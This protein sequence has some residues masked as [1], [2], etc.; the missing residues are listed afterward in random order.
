VPKAKG[1]LGRGLSALIPQSPT[2]QPEEAVAPSASE[3]DPPVGSP[4][5][6]TSSA[7]GGLVNLPI[8]SIEP[9]PRQPR[10]NFAVDRL[11]ELAESIRT[12]GVIQPLVVTFGAENGR[13]HLVAGER[14]WRASMLAGLE[15]VP[16]VV[17]DA[18]PREMLEL[19]LVENIQRADLNPLEEAAAYRALVD[20][21]GLKQEE[22]ADRVGKSR[23]AVSNVM[24]LLSLP[25]LVQEALAGGLIKEGHARPLLQLEDERSQ[26][27]LLDQIIRN[28]LS[29]RQV[30]A[31]ARRLAATP[32]PPEEAK[33]EEPRPL[34]DE[35]KELEERFIH[36]LSAKVSLSKSRRGGKLTIYFSSDEELDRIYSA[37]VG[38][39]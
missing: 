25:A 2:V 33:A 10:Q 27:W 36:A 39:E 34:F 30:E 6:G 29:V 14:R 20:E 28:D 19:A 8:A 37:I 17:K 7:A 12:H 35:W 9:N 38:D 15:S 24:R 3:T 16:A 31:L 18:S 26:L 1:G 21:F 4:P 32:N 13:Y 22:V 5:D 23:A 11:E